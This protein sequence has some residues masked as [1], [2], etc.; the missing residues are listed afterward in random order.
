M[1]RPGIPSLAFMSPGLVRAPTQRS[2]IAE[3]VGTYIVQSV[4]PPRLT[5]RRTAS[6]SPNPLK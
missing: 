4:A 6:V 2:W 3:R 1:S 5:M